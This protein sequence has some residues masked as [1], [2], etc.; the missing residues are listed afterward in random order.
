MTVQE[1]V[2]EEQEDLAVLVK[3]KI[4]YMN[5]INKEISSNGDIVRDNEKHT[6]YFDIIDENKAYE[7]VNHPEHY[8]MYSTEVIDMMENIWGT[9]A[10]ALWCE[11]TAFK[12]RMRMG[13]KPENPI[14]Q[15]IKKENWYLNKAKELR[16]KK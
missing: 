10:T 2:R 11:M 3:N 15:D 9:E 12:Y 4:R 1:S 14:E 7:M 16:N 6:P 13:T 5:N 8:N